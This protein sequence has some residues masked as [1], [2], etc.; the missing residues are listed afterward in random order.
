MGDGLGRNQYQIPTK[1]VQKG[2]DQ[3]EGNLV[4]SEHLACS[5]HFTE[6][7][8]HITG[9]LPNS[10][11]QRR[12]PTRPRPPEQPCPL[13]PAPWALPPAP[14]HSLAL[15]TGLVHWGCMHLGLCPLHTVGP[16]PSPLLISASVDEK[17]TEMDWRDLLECLKVGPVPHH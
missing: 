4:F 9:F 7:L 8:S 12:W 15:H 10:Q 11:T 17:M 1:G 13:P 16:A 6:G 14:M 2:K 3:S 5:T